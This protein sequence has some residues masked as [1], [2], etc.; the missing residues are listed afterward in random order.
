ML[1]PTFRAVYIARLTSG[2]S[3]PVGRV[4]EWLCRGLQILVRRFNSGPG[5]QFDRL[6]K[7]ELSRFAAIA[8]KRP[9]F[10]PG[11]ERVS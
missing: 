8:I 9:R 6:T 1:D 3:T 11:I 7:I 10:I 2:G 4:A 5:L